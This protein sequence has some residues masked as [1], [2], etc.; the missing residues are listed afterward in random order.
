MTD[1]VRYGIFSIDLD[2]TLTLPNATDETEKASF[3]SLGATMERIKDLYNLDFI[4]VSINSY[5]SDLEQLTRHAK[6][7]EK[8]GLKGIHFTAEDIITFKYWE[9]GFRLINLNADFTTHK[10]SYRYGV[11]IDPCGNKEQ[12]LLGLIRAEHK[13]NIAGNSHHKIVCVFHVEDGLSPLYFAEP[14]R[15]EMA[16][17]G[18][19]FKTIPL[20]KFAGRIEMIKAINKQVLNITEVDEDAD[21]KLMQKKLES[22]FVRKFND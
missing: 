9:P 18:I 14:F 15:D 6:E 3:D 11:E 10:E 5:T 8:R 19:E 13:R 20:E 2:G 17:M 21:K 22:S 4:N 16:A 12:K 7:L 1:E